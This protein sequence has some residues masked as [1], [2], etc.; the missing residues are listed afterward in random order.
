MVTELKDVARETLDR[1]VLIHRADKMVFRFEQDFVIGIVGNGAAGGERGQPRAAPAAQHVIDRVVV[2]ERAAAPAT[3]AEALRNHLDDRREI[4]TRQGAIG[5]GAA[6]QSEETL[7]APFARGH[8]GDDLLRQNIERVFGDAETIE[9]AAGDRIEQRGAF[10]Q[11]VARQREQP[12][13]GSAGDSMARTP[14]ALQER[15]DR[16]RGEPNWQTRSTSPMS[17][18]NSSEAVATSAFSLPYLRRC[19]ASKRCSLARLP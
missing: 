2:D 10:D 13:L 19:S 9:L 11:L 7:F 5:P 14:D 4:F 12:S 15:R 1:E 16:A 6:H 18:P 8:F 17:M 3:R